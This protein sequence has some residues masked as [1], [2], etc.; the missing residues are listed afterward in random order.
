MTKSEPRT[1]T[2]LGAWNYTT[3][4]LA[5]LLVG[6]IAFLLISNYL[7]Q[8]HL[9]EHALQQLRQDTEKRASV[10]SYFFSER[11]SDLENLAASQVISSFFENRALGMSLEYGLHASLLA[12]GE[13]FNRF[14]EEER[15]GDQRIY[16]ILRFV[17]RNGDILVDTTADISGQRSERNW[18]SYLTPTST[19]PVIIAQG[20]KMAV[21]MPY[22]FKNQYQGQIIAW[23]IPQSVYDQLV[24]GYRSKGQFIGI[25]SGKDNFYVPEDM[26]IEILFSGLSDLRR[27]EVG[28][29]MRF[30]MSDRKGI[31]IEMVSTKVPV[32][33]TPFS[34]VNVLPATE[35]FGPT[36]PWHLLL[37]MG[38]VAV[39]VLVGLALVWRANAQRI[40][41]RTRLDEAAIR[42]REIEEKKRQLEKEIVERE[43]AEEALQKSKE[44]YRH[45]VEDMPDMICRFLLDGTL[46]FVNHAYCAYFNKRKEELLGGNFFQFIPEGE[47]SKVREH[48][49]SLTQDAP[50]IT[51]EHQAV[52]P[53]GS[54]R[55]QEWNDRAL[56]DEH[57]DL[58]EYQSIGNDITERKL[59]RQE[60][61][62]L[63]R[64]LQ[65]AQKMEAV[66]TLAGGISHDFN[67]LLQ[68][69]Q[70]Y[71]QLLLLD[72]DGDEP[73]Y[74]ELQEI[75]RAA[76]RGGE[77]TQQML[78]FS[79][80]VESH[81][82]PID[83]NQEVRG[84][85]RLLERTIP[86]MIEIELLLVDNLWTVDADPVQM[87]QILMNLAVNAKD[88]MPEGGRLVIE[89]ENVFLDEEY[90]KAHLGAKAG[91]YVLLR[92]SDNGHGIDRRTLEH[93]FEP[94]FSTKEAGKG[95]G[96]GLAMVYGIVKSHEGHIMCYSEPGEG[97][98]F[99]IYLP[100]IERPSDGVELTEAETPPPG[101]SETILLVDDEQ[102]VREL[103]ERFLSTFGYT[104]VVASDA[105]SAL[106]LYREE[107]YRPELVILDLIMPGMGGSRCLEGLL[108]ID[109]EAK[110]LIA[111]GYS[112]QGPTREIL[113]AGAK[114]FVSKPYEVRQLLEAAREVL[115]EN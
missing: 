115:D 20:S 36:T 88:A 74:R 69:V 2:L 87:E 57:G 43:R 107:Q 53:D 11:K 29:T 39:I 113:N 89:T 25:S 96:L 100:V 77:L 76:K 40:V 81:R 85:K 83:L 15:I 82:R 58:V 16:T 114:G 19:E 48:F 110:V 9:R 3:V 14:V 26:P 61:A 23:I 62:K 105:E 33:E 47:Q 10:V 71:A 94:F 99:K 98:T 24:K 64:Q 34:L 46:T 8:M 18:K 5:L 93:I 12:I 51:Y 101:G 45:V 31:Q 1:K 38:A 104:V 13:R 59:A 103:G 65:H 92:I 68:A 78:T 60:K 84:V 49:Q 106:E 80:K 91:G 30:W 37:V 50:M 35:V 79:R 72:K 21:S 6:F 73:G 44:R 112:P 75:L 22:Y 90:C 63:E 17:D 67:N 108:E 95:T 4:A 54:T 42:E 28:D 109:P 41:L 27:L 70:G 97:T 102:S 52:A 56:F 86:K 55:W 32:K 66:G 7:S 111:S